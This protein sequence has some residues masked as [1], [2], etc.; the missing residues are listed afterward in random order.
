MGSAKAG[1]IFVGSKGLKAE[2]VEAL[3]ALATEW[4][5]IEERLKEA[6]VQIGEAVNPS[7]NELRY[8]G[9]VFV[10]AWHVAAKK[11]GT[12]YK[13][14]EKIAVA[15]QYLQNAKHDITDAVCLYFNK[16]IKDL[17]ERYKRSTIELGY[18]NLK[19]F[20]T[21]MDEANVIVTG[22][23]KNR[24]RR[25]EAYER[26]ETDYI[27]YLLQ[28]FAKLDVAEKMAAAHESRLRWFAVVGY[29]VGAIGF[30]GSIASIVSILWL[31]SSCDA[32]PD[33]DL[34]NSQALCE[35]IE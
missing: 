26:L 1:P 25:R 33:I 18:P 30:V 21:K 2:H 3:D 32:S 29:I 31:P 28:E 34:Q 13:L 9:R 22:S 4:D 23:R 20:L 27:P 11:D 12:E 10:D 16:K 35:K 8:A 15:E 7:V 14:E 5:K 6:E 24:T 19:E 17:L